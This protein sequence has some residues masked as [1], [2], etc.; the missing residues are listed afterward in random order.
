MKTNVIIFLMLLS[1]ISGYAQKI[2]NVELYIT[3]RNVTYGWYDNGVFQFKHNK[4]S[5]KVPYGNRT[6]NTLNTKD[7]VFELFYT[8][9]V[10]SDSLYNNLIPQNNIEIDKKRIMI[11][12]EKKDTLFIDR[13]YNLIKKDK[14]YQISNEVKSFIEKYMPPEIKENWIND[15]SGR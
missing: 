15:L 4:K 1:P 14:C 8:K 6:Y 7:S 13:N 3:P 12:I 10:M 5:I 2:K 11:I 9:T